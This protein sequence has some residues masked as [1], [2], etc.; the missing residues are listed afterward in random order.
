MANA[1]KKVEQQFFRRLN[2]LVEPLVRSGL[3]SLKWAPASLIVLESTGFKSGQ[4]R[5]TP[6]SSVRLG[7]YR[8]VAT[9]RGKRSFWVRNLQKNPDVS[10]FVGGEALPAEAILVA[11]DF[12]NLDDWELSSLMSQLMAGLA[13]FVKQGWAFAILV[14]AK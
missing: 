3:G 14:P 1:M 10:Y 4:S 9:A 2:N 11:P 8:I 13:R 12:N 7:Q 6:L 5:R